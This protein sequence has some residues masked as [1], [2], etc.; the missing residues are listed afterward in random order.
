ME[1][2]KIDVS[3]RL[4]SEKLSTLNALD[5]DSNEADTR[6][7]V[8]DTM[9][10]DILDWRK[11][12]VETELYCRTAGY[13][14]YVC[15]ANGSRILVIE[16]K[17]RGSTFLLEGK[18]FE[19]RPYSFGFLSTESKPAADALQQA[20]GYAATLGVPYVAITNGTQWLLAL[21]YVTGQTLDHRLV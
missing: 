5:L 3:H 11:E 9:L 8:I 15:S 14:D 6:L 17:R 1:T 4:L 19:S 16:A 10:F 7:R 20:I 18:V 12:D 13:A 21:T 2:I